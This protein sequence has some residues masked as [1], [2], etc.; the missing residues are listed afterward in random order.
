[1]LNL[2]TKL[3]LSLI[4]LHQNCLSTPLVTIITSLYKGEKYIEQFLQDI[5]KQ[6][7]FDK[8]ELIMINANSPEHEEKYIKK[9]VKKFKNII[10]VRLNNDPG[11]YAV[12]NMAIQMAQAPFITN[13]NVDDRLKND[14]YQ[15]HLATLLR[16][17]DI[18][19]VYSD[20]YYTYRANET[21]NMNSKKRKSKLAEFSP[22]ALLISC[23]PNN[24][25]M[26][27]KTLHEKYGFFD[28][29]YKSAGDWELWLRA[30]SKGAKFLKVDGAFGLFYV[31]PK[32]LSTQQY[33]Q[34]AR[35]EPQKFLP[36]YSKFAP[37]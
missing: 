18:D 7:I 23:L 30:V 6:T 32:G 22:E 3:L 5:T 13:A 14:C 12:W 36:L 19:L 33:N 20:Y 35:T 29:S 34:H 27:R 17:P 24:H 37:K 1:M 31:N 11:L 2:V 16:N 21:F 25:P 26:W 10:Y 8:C 9:Y 15:T 4:L 28:A